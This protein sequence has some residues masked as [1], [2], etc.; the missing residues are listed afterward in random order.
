M[1][2]RIV[3]TRPLLFY[4]CR[5]K[6]TMPP[7]AR[8]RKALEQ[9]N[10]AEENVKKSA[11]S[12][13]TRWLIKSEPDTRMENG[14]DMKFGF[15]DLKAEPDSTACWDGVRNYSARNN[16]RT[17]RVGQQAFFYH[18]NTKPPGI[19]GIVDIVKEA[20]VDHTQFDRK[21]PHFD[22]ASKKDNPK[23]SMV[24]VK[25]VRPTRRYIPLDELKRV[26]LEHKTAGGPLAGLSL[27]TKARLSVMPISEEEWDFILE[28][29]DA[30]KK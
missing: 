9:V 27:F 24:D 14:I 22:A 30:E 5:F 18:S 23:W 6:F 20:Y 16:M 21:D 28:M 2:S 8:K 29:E 15:Q 1:L 4:I 7:K 25:Y 13:P 12:A 17:M 11:E 3:K 19:V 10:T 26:H